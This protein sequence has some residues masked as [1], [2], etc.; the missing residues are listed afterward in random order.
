VAARP[1]IVR[2][3]VLAPNVWRADGRDDVALRADVIRD[4][5]ETNVRARAGLDVVPRSDIESYV[6]D[7]THAGHSPGQDE[8][9]IAV[10]ANEILAIHLVCQLSCQITLERDPSAPGGPRSALFRMA[11]DDFAHPAETIDVNLSSLYPDH[12]VRNA[13]RTGSIDPDDHKR[14]VQLVHDY[15]A[16]G[17]GSTSSADLLAQL[18]GMRTRAPRSI[19]V[20]LFEVE[21][22]RHR[23][24]QTEDSAHA[25]RALTVLQ[26]AAKLLPDTYDILSARFDI[27][28]AAGRLDEAGAVL[29]RLA[30]QDPDSSAT[31]LQLAKLHERRGELER[32]RREFEQARDELDAAA[33]RDSFSWRVLYYRAVVFQKLGDRRATGEAIDQLLK[34]SP[35]NYGGLSLRASEEL[36]AGRLACAA[37]IYSRLVARKP[38]YQESVALGY[39]LNQLARYRE[40]AESFHRALDTRP[41]D[42]SALLDLGE[43]LLLAGNTDDARAQLRTLR[44][45]LA[46]KRRGSPGNALQGDDLLVEAQTLAYLGRNDPDLV[47]EARACVAALPTS[48]APRKILYTAALVYAI[49]RDRKLAAT[50]VT[51]YLDAG[52]SAAELGY[53]WFD[54]LR[55][56]RVLGPRLTVPPID[57][58]CDVP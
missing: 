13:D 34:R 21:V 24:V 22:L 4:A 6:Y 1:P 11:A 3:A 37:Q 17:T 53:P 12:R 48:G 56:D 30:T 29:D 28:V 44:E 31:H 32:A 5:V 55:Q 42:P 38:L 10:G 50:Y 39:T 40:A 7:A 54:D 33:H 20:I 19:D 41:D 49:L 52:G 25:E 23:Y 58:S 8:T 14:Y 57:R 15:W 16:G 36:D 45:I 18:E 47:N 46:R 2:V 9:R 27:L 43:S 35:G 26:D 51:K